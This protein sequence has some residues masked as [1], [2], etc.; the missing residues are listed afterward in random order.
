MTAEEFMAKEARI[1]GRACT[2]LDSRVLESGPHRVEAVTYVVSPGST[3]MRQY[4]HAL[5]VDGRDIW[6]GVTGHAP[7]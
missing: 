2:L 3:K 5:L 1:M 4:R 6:C 7:A